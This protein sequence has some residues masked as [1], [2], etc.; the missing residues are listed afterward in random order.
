V[1]VEGKEKLKL[2]DREKPTDTWEGQ[3][4]TRLSSWNA[5]RKRPG[6]IAVFPK[7]GRYKMTTV[8]DV[9]ELRTTVALL[10]DELG[11]GEKRVIGVGTAH[12]SVSADLASKIAALAA[13]RAKIAEPAS[14]EISA[15]A[16]ACGWCCCCCCSCCCG[17]CCCSCCC[18]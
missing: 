15:D 11:L 12:Q 8:Y 3:E 6:V 4:W 17:S 13:K 10:E 2:Q 18:C 7:S 1:E 16:E 9:S 14:A 5:L